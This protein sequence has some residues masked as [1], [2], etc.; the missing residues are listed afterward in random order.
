MK[1]CLHRKAMM[2]DSLHAST[3]ATSYK[4]LTASTKVPA[5]SF[6]RSLSCPKEKESLPLPDIAE[7]GLDGIFA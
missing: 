1:I 3:S 5:G 7:R 4:A 6:N 2:G